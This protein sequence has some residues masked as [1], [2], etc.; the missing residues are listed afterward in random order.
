VSGID[1]HLGSSVRVRDT[2]GDEE[3][4][5]VPRGE[6][7]ILRGT[8]SVASPVGRA[9]LGRRQGEEV[10]VRTP[11]GI[12]R[13]TILGIDDPTLRGIEARGESHRS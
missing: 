4:T 9:L 1:V 10:V 7:D 2:C 3:Y 6:A 11:G 8:I 12:R 13:L 5:I